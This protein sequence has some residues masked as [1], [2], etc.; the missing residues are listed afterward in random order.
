M[1]RAGAPALVV[2][3]RVA[4]Q[5]A[6]AGLAAFAAFAGLAGLAGLAA[7]AGLA[8]LAGCERGEVALEV[9]PHRLIPPPDPATMP[10]ARAAGASG[11]DPGYVGEAACA[12]CHAER[13]ASVRQTSHFRTSAKVTRASVLGPTDASASV[14]TGSSLS[15]AVVERGGELWQQAIDDARDERLSRRMDV[16]IGSGKLAQ[17]FL[18]WEQ[19]RLYELPMTWFAAVGWRFSPG[20]WEDRADFSRPA[21]AKCLE[22][23]ALWAETGNP[24][25]VHDNSFVG[26]ILWGVT[27][28]RCHGPGREHIAWQ[29]ANP[30]AQR[31]AKIIVPSD[32]PR[33][34]RDDICLLCHATRGDEKLP[35]FS[36]RPGDDLRA[37]YAAPAPPT[38]DPA[39][40]DTLHSFD[41][42]DRM[43]ASRCFQ[44]SSMSCIT[45]HDPHRMERGDDAA[46]VARCLG[47][48]E[49]AALTKK[50]GETK[51][52]GKTSCL[53]CHM[54]KRGTEAER[55]VGPAG[56]AESRVRMR[57][58]RIGIY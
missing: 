16:V 17:T 20:Y 15:I 52:D 19:D 21:V 40:V 29:H 26:P 44:Q 53:D 11:Y 58:H 10:V 7:F 38:V 32:L 37:H 51:H 31:A 27:C 18:T 42:G 35:V 54:P 13:V 23:H 41:Q 56:S 50:P 1:A 36:F 12:E 45:C 25:L 30:R 39:H 33:E 4:A 28:E 9:L 14:R 8:G 49:A 48:H 24:E 2:V 55:R 47:C 6:F 43:H 46:F 22:C 57:D 34:R 3:V 5:A